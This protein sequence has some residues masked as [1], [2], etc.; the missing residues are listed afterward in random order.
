M[1]FRRYLKNVFCPNLSVES[2][3]QLFGILEYACGLKLGP[4]LTLNQNPIFEIAS[5]KLNLIFSDTDLEVFR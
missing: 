4:A 1:E 5:S 3:F 2:S